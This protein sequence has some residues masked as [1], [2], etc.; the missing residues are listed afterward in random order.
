MDLSKI[1]K[2]FNVA[3]DCQQQQSVMQ[4][5][6]LEK[7]IQFL[8]QKIRQKNKERFAKVVFDK[9]ENGTGM[10]FIKIA[11]CPWKDATDE[12]LNN[13]DR[14]FVIA[15][16]GFDDQGQFDED[17]TFGVDMIRH[18]D[19]LNKTKRLRAKS[20][21]NLVD[22]GDYVVKYF[23]N[24]HEES[25]SP[26]EADAS[27]DPALLNTTAAIAKYPQR[28]GEPFSRPVFKQKKRKK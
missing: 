10:L 6:N 18:Q 19:K 17:C 23:N 5:T 2:V 28:M 1:E 27:S 4:Q 11:N 16:D 3:N 15:I 22:A 26:A 21:Y 14:N 9:T 13:S 12:A 20:F 8:K 24:I 25:E 7:F